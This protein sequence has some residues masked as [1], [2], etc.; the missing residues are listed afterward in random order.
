MS[1]PMFTRAHSRYTR[2]SVVKDGKKSKLLETK[3]ETSYEH[4]KIVKASEEGVYE[5]IS[6]QDKYCSFSVQKDQGIGKRLLQY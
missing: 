3:L 6:I 1:D 4:T 2:S 5:V